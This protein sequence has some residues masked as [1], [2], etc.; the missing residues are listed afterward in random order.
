[1]SEYLGA[2][3][4][5]IFFSAVLDFLDGRIARKLKVNSEFGIELDS[6]AD[7]VSFGVAPALLFHTMAA[8]SILTS[9]AFI[10]F[11]TMGALRLAKFSIQPTIGYFKALPISAAGLSFAGIGLFSYSNA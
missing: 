11:P 6:L 8:P 7:I 4:I 1:M 2:A 10:L 5:L 3:S 9:L